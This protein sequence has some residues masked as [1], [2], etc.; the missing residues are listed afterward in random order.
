MSAGAK[1]MTAYEIIAWLGRHVERSAHLCL[2]SRQL[3]PGDVFFA[4]PGEQDDGRDF[5][6]DA[7]KQGAAAIVAQEGGP[8]GRP[9]SVP[10]LEVPRLRDML[11][12]VAHHWYREPS[13]A[14]SVVAV[15]G[16]NG[17]TSCVSW[18]AHALNAEG[19]ACGTIGTLGVVLPDGQRLGGALTTPDV[20]SMHRS[21]ARLRDAGAMVVALEAS[22]IGIVQGRLDHVRLEIAAFTNLTVDH[23]DYHGDMAAYQAAKARLFSW[24]QL[25]AA[26]INLDDEV[27]RRLAEESTASAI[28]GYSMM[29]DRE[30]DVQALNIEPSAYGL[31]FELKT[32]R[33]S[34]QILTRLVGQHNISNLL[35]VAGVLRQLGWG[36]ARLVR[37]LGAL[38]PVEGRLQV[39]EPLDCGEAAA[40]PMVVVDYAHTPDALERALV[41][42]APMATARGGRLVCIFGC[43]GARDRSKRPLMARV[44]VAH[45][46]HVVLSN[47]NPRDEA[48]EAIIRDI[49]AGVA[50]PLP[51]ELDRARAILSAIWLGDHRDVIL[52]A[53]K[54]HETTQEFR[55]RVIAF[56]DRAWARLA[57]SW[58]RGVHLSTDS[59]SL[60]PGEL[61]LALQGEHF[62]GHDFLGQVAESGA[63]GAIVA[64]RDDSLDL[65]QIVVED[66]REALA[67]MAA[68]WRRRFELPLV[69]VTGSNGKTTTKE[70]IAAILR[71]WLGE[72][73]VLATQGN[74]NNDIGVPLTLLRMAARHQ[75]AVVE[76]G[77]N[78]PGE[79]SILA[80]W[81]AP[82]IGLVN[83]AQRE[84]QE[85]MHTV[86]A[87]AR[88]NG[89]VIQAL[90][91]SGIAVFPGDDDYTALWQGMAEGRECIRFGFDERFEVHADQ[92][93]VEPASTSFQLHTPQGEAAV[94]LQARGLHNLRNA[95]AACACALAA[96]VPL[97]FIVRGLQAFHPVVGRMRT[98]ILADGTQII[99]DSYNA[100]PDSVRAA[101]DVLADLPGRAV[102]VLGDMGE[103]GADSVAAHV[104]MGSYARERGLA[105]VLTLGELSRHA[106]LAFGEEAH[107]FMTLEALMQALGELLPAHVLVKGS[108][109]ARMERVLQALDE[110]LGLGRGGNQGAA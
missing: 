32:S 62:D 81:A 96:R 5:M 67:L 88:E 26:V 83:N 107:A 49:Q 47:D 109:S 70:M 35:L 100:N 42:L 9:G 98:R 20:L 41:A 19:V 10:A 24:P 89:A 13:H 2:D 72:E 48:P 94:V 77:M 84:H 91:S 37:V 33:G 85:F 106:A 50:Q 54:G 79:I 74:L 92:I 46:D 30:A 6:T 110:H 68:V 76:M 28:L 38:L 11:G 60:A 14:V 59:R 55:S 57:L 87:V 22:S 29:P 4:C 86:E 71:A 34:A 25:N 66:T 27:G 93:H 1:A 39:V 31:V 103:I 105:A 23:L 53:G 78:H 75:A 65:E 43:G 44:A 82:T 99:D 90:P 97:S 63:C 21:L 64:Y 8:A 36:M 61:F 56:D 73:A 40:T 45:A 101:I 3:E 104:E 12:A 95:L 17:K 52:I 102:L 18:I 15:T 108:R 7:I 16:T 58:M 80:Q 69:G 51:V